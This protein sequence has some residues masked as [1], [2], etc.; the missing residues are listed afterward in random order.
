MWEEDTSFIQQTLRERH[1]QARQTGSAGGCPRVLVHGESTYM[2]SA[3][4]NPCGGR[5]TE[6]PLLLFAEA[7]GRGVCWCWEGLW[8]GERGIKHHTTLNATPSEARTGGRG[9]GTF[10]EGK[11][12]TASPGER[13]GSHTQSNSSQDP[14]DEPVSVTLLFWCELWFFLNRSG[15]SDRKG[16]KGYASIYTKYTAYAHLLRQTAGWRVPGA[17]GP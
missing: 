3:S 1:T 13:M 12:G 16:H 8:V 14:G 17:L 10:R 2:F 7:W 15:K 4:T 6:S 11:R 5:L 9:K